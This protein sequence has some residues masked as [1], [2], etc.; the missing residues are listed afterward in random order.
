MWHRPT[1]NRVLQ[2]LR[3][4]NLFN[5]SFHISPWRWNLS[6]ILFQNCQGDRVILLIQ[7]TSTLSLIISS[8]ESLESSLKPET[9]T[10]GN[11]LIL[12]WIQS[13]LVL[14]MMPDCF[15]FHS[16]TKP[17]WLYFRMM[18]HIKVTYS[19][20]KRSYLKEKQTEVKWMYYH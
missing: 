10:D 6:P 13:L 5:F 17:L 16:K 8:F 18:A 1:L 11:I 15:K 7:G 14:L 4:R 19:Y 9:R 20:F 2:I 3:A 12:T